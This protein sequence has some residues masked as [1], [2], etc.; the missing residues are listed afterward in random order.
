MNVLFAALVIVLS[1]L[2][3]V[4]GGDRFVDTCVV[5]AKKLKIPTAVVGATLT[6]IGTT[7]P[8]LLVTIFSS[9]S[10]AGGLAVGNALGSVI[11]NACVIG[12]VLFLFLTVK[13]DSSIQNMGVLLLFSVFIIFLM[14]LN[15]NISLPE[16]IL[17]VLLFA[18]FVVLN[19]IQTKKQNNLGLQPVNNTRPIKYHLFMFLVSA[20]AIAV[21]AYF[22]V[23][24]AK[25]LA[26][27][28]KFSDTLIGLT[29]VC[30][31][32]SLPELV[33]TISAI[34]KKEAGLGIGNIVGSNIINCCLLIGISGI[35]TGGNLLVSTGTKFITIPIAIIAS[36]LLLVPC[37]IK[38]S[39]K[40][41]GAM[42][43]AVY[44]VY[45]TYLFL[46]AFL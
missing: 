15:G 12:G 37:M 28:L 22:L 4:W 39:K 19:Y 6:S 2:L 5:L 24:K 32:T 14:S 17:L 7:L 21:G 36:L 9:T 45:Y 20:C 1:F 8:E 33:T 25:M 38:S 18:V 13:K 16:L 34:R 40:W 26:K 46:S 3:I 43:L 41:Q 10:G 42:L 27:L 29:I 44:A 11:F 23:N 31:G 30:I 35:L